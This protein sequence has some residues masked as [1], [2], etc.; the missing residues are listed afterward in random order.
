MPLG[1]L[2]FCRGILESLWV[3]QFDFIRLFQKG[4]EIPIPPK[5]PNSLGVEVH[6]KTAKYFPSAHLSPFFH[7]NIR[8][9]IYAP[10]IFI[11]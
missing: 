6:K 2:A 11:I 7:P 1:N 8:F 3:R 5:N 9:C 4:A 10:E